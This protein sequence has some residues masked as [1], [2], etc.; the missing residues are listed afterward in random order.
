MVADF[1]QHIANRSQI[2][3]LIYNG[4]DIVDW[5][6][7]G[8]CMKRSLI[9]VKWVSMSLASCLLALSA[10]LSLAAGGTDTKAASPSQQAAQNMGFAFIQS[11]QEARIEQI[12]DK[13]NT[14]LLTLKNI[15]PNVS[16]IS[17]RPQ[18]K[19]GTLPN[20]RFIQEWYGQA[21]DSFK[22]NPPNAFLH[23]LQDGK[24]E[25][26]DANAKAKAK[27]KANQPPP[28]PIVVNYAI[29]LSEPKL[30][31]KANT[32]TYVVNGLESKDN[33]ISPVLLR[34]ITLF[35]DEAPCLT[36]W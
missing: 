24:K 1:H 7:Q 19:T 25:K 15:H 18:R 2:Q 21:K 14:F 31:T 26:V 32:I 23:G 8:G 11:A 5:Y 36:C 30:D 27:P 33:V 3:I 9:G 12:V 20:E 28:E 29:Q 22:N 35:I 34:Y 13:P 6:S 4:N 10:P 17:E 16:F